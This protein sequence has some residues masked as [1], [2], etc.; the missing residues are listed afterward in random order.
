MNLRLTEPFKTK[1]FLQDCLQFVRKNTFK[2][3]LCIKYINGPSSP[4]SFIRIIN[5]LSYFFRALSL[6]YSNKF[7]FI[8][9]LLING[10]YYGVIW[11]QYS[12]K[13]IYERKA[14]YGNAQTFIN[15]AVLKVDIAF[16][17]FLLFQRK[18]SLKIK[19]KVR[20]RNFLN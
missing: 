9:I 18:K 20:L 4:S 1:Y 10:S 14:I 17:S 2:Y 12:G 7:L 3:F 19:P 5:G 6:I 8:R 16:K 13:K 15:T 11:R